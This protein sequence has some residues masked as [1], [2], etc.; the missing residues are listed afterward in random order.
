MLLRRRFGM[1]HNATVALLVGVCVIYQM[2][3]AVF[4]IPCYAIKRLERNGLSH[5]MA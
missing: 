4:Q 3:K 2:K 5:N 1:K